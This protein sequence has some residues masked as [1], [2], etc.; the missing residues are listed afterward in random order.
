MLRIFERRILRIIYG[1]IKENGIWKS[2]YNHEL[3]QICNEPDM[4][5]DQSRAAEMAGT[6]VC[7]AGAEP[8]QE[9]NS[10]ETSG[11]ST[12]RLYRNKRV[13]DE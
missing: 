7:N 1:P 6:T 4:V 9:V 12:S 2:R 10:T 13:L 11:Y 8:L 5:S 3:H